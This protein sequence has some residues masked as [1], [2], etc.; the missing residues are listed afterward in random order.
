MYDYYRDNILRHMSRNDYNPLKQRALAKAM[1]VSDDQYTTFKQ[2]LGQLLEAGQVVQSESKAISLPELG[3]EMVGTFQSSRGSFGFVLP[4]RPNSHGDLFVPRGQCLDAVSGDKVRARVHWRG[5]R[6]GQKRYIGQIVEILQRN[7]HEFVGSVIKQGHQW[8][9]E[10]DGKA[11]TEIIAVDDPSAKNVKVGDK[12]LVEILT[13]AK[14]DYYANG[15]VIEKLGK[16]GSSPAE[17]KAIIR[18]YGITDRFSRSARNEAS[19]LAAEFEAEIKEFEAEVKIK[20]GLREDS[21]DKTIITID[22]KD[23]RDFDDAISLQPLPHHRWLL[24]VHIADVSYF[25]RDGSHLDKQARERATS[26]YLPQHV[27]PMLPELL[28][29]GVCSLQ[30]GH[31]RFVKSVYI[32]LDNDGSVLSTRFA[33]SVIRSSQR[34]T[35]ED[36]ENILASDSDCF[37]IKVV[38][39]LKNMEK[40]ARILEKRRLNRGMLTLDLPEVELVYDSKGHV[41]GAHPTSDSYPHKIIE[42]FMVE[43]NEAVARLLDSLNVPF[44]RRIHP[45]PETIAAS[46]ATGIVKLCGYDVPKAINRKGMQQLLDAVR[47][48]PESFMI[49]LA[50]L[51]TLQPAEYSPASVGHFALASEYYTHFTSPIRRYPD[52]TTH[53]LLQKYIEGKLTRKTA[54]D[55]ADYAEMKAIGRYCTDAERNAEN[56]ERELR[57]VKILGLLEKRIG[58]DVKAVVTSITNFGMFVQLEEFLT[59]GL[60]T[61]EEVDRVLA[62]QS[63]QNRQRDKKRKGKHSRSRVGKASGDTHKFTNRCPYRLGQEIIV[64]IA[65]VNIPRRRIEL[66]P[67]S[68]PEK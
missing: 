37:D 31:D 46:E 17:L 47:G 49:N 25:V 40:L 24:G 26:V 8:F 9:V 21:R 14:E 19:S 39:L 30:V 3:R 60:V 35:Y 36:A 57:T 29:N 6:E 53:R 63:Q 45:E 44:I 62:G 23:A 2:A 51:K 20:S 32:K 66:I 18:Q 50:I 22:P 56:A 41:T 10:P 15:V 52:L 12:V 1:G 67:I 27:I 13:F 54:G 11:V 7:Q 68:L 28:S 48:K 33:N 5:K 43:A 4:D 64:R 34:L 65:G 16:S 59:D 55:F 58:Q 42:M 38:K 61:A